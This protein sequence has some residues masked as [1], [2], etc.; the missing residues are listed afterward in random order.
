M[1][2]ASCRLY[3]DGNAATEPARSRVIGLLRRTVVVRRGLGWVG[4]G[5]VNNEH[6]ARKC[7][8]GTRQSAGKIT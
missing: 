5:G 4:W 3:S 2:A 6:E 8:R 1:A 7:R